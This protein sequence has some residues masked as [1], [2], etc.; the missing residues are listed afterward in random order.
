MIH[1]FIWCV[2]T[3]SWMCITWAFPILQKAIYSSQRIISCFSSRVLHLTVIY[4]EKWNSSSIAGKWKISYLQMHVFENPGSECLGKIRGYFII[5]GGLAHRHWAVVS[6][7]TDLFGS[8][9]FQGN[10]S[11][12][13]TWAGQKAGLCNHLEAQPATEVEEPVTVGLPRSQGQMPSRRIIPK[14]TPGLQDSQWDAPPSGTEGPKLASVF[15]S[16]GVT[17]HRRGRILH[18]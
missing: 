1:I 18:K 15:Q 3:C 6:E 9:L 8:A 17:L 4:K 11:S 7:Q 10:G 5:L 2:Y 14:L 13:N 16:E 12:P